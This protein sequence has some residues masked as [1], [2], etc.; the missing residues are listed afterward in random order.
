MSWREEQSTLRGTKRPNVVVFL[1]DQQRWDSAGLHGNPLGL[2]P[3]LDRLGGQG[4][5]IENA[6]SCQPVCAPARAVL[7]TGQ[8]ATTN[9]VFRNGI[10]LSPDRRTIA[11]DF[12]AAGYDTAYIGKWHLAGSTVGARSHE[13]GGYEYWR[14]IDAA[15]KLSDVYDAQLYDNDGELRHLP[16]Y[17]P[18]AYVDE[19]IRFFSQ[20]RTDRPFLLFVALVEPHQKNQTDEYEAPLAYRDAYDSAWTP[21]DL[22]ALGGNSSQSLGGYWGMIKRIDEAFGRLVDALYSENIANST[23]LVFTS[24]HG[25]HFRTRNG[26]YKRSEHESSVRVPMVLSGPGLDGG[27]RPQSLVSLIDLPPT[28]LDA[29]GIDVP[30]R[31]QGRSFMPLLGAD[32]ASSWPDEVYIQISESQVGRALR[33]KRWKYAVTAPEGDGWTEAESTQYVETALYDLADDPYEL[34]NLVGQKRWDSVARELRD[35]LVRQIVA[36]GEK[37][38]EIQP[39]RR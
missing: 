10:A 11:H 8:Y 31:M 29:A 9:G 33:T 24:D 28:L 23:I 16:G 12:S 39:A 37:A 25:N 21:P 15:G 30:A 5:V 6:F 13:R 1:T 22:A 38:P 32:G 26:E 34:T 3:N 14:G 20:H 4:T 2:T 17:R 27:H 18:D 36:A 35:R 7:Q 19:A